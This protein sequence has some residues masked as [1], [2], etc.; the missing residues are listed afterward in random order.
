[1]KERNSLAILSDKQSD[2]FAADPRDFEV[3]EA[4]DSAAPKM[5]TPFHGQCGSSD[6]EYGR[7]LRESAI[8]ANASAPSET[9]EV[10][11]DVNTALNTLKDDGGA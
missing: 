8:R 3:L 4:G 7:L 1:M 6:A 5:A 2:P 9:P 10:H 11:P